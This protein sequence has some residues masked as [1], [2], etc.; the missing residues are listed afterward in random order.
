MIFCFVFCSYFFLS[1]PLVLLSSPPY[2]Y[3]VSCLLSPLFHD[4]F[5]FLYCCTHICFFFLPPSVN[6]FL[7]S[8]IF[9]LVSLLSLNFFTQLLL[10]PLLFL[11]V[12]LHFI[13]FLSLFLFLYCQLPYTFVDPPVPTS[14]SYV[15][16]GKQVDFVCV[17]SNARCA[18]YNRMNAIRS[19]LPACLPGVPACL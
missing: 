10:P 2:V 13:H 14:L 11:L 18:R 4:F 19:A 5:M 12:V 9:P 3:C 16:A 7:I 6:L 8:F 17:I 15:T 1:V